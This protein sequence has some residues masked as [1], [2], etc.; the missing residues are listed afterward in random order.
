MELDTDRFDI[1]PVERRGI[2]LF[3]DYVWSN[4]EVC[5]HCFTR[6]R[7]IG[8]LREVRM[9]ELT[10]EVNEFY[11]RTEDGSQ[12]HHPFTLPSDRYGT[13][14]CENCGSDTQPRHHHL[15]WDKMRE[16]SINLYNYVSDHTPLSLSSESFARHLAHLRLE[17]LDTAGRESQIFA[18]AF[19]RALES[20]APM[21][22]GEKRPTANS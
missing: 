10:H 3:K 15:P 11:E 21:A 16:Y 20:R 4:S 1:G 5:S 7:S 12:E 9:Q 19:A 17:R 6:V 2:A 14:F 18:V 8:E 13:C 22:G